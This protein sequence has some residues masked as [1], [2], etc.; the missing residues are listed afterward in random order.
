MIQIKDILR[1]I[2]SRASFRFAE[3]WDNSG[4]QVG[5]PDFAVSKVMIALDPATG[6]LREAHELGCQC[7]VTHHPLLLQAVKSIWTDRWPGSVIALAL[8]SGIGI[9]AAHTNLDAARE[10]TNAQLG[11][12]LGLEDCVPLEADADLFADE[13]YLGM[14]IVG[15]LPR[16][17]TLEKLAHELRGML[18]CPAVRVTGEPH[19]KISRVA[20]CTGSGGS[21][22]GKVLAFRADVFLTGDMKYHDARLAEESGLAVI[23]I[24]H[25]ASEKLVL[26]PLGEYLGARAESEGEKLEI[27]ISGT[28]KDP[29]RIPS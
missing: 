20:L 6:V 19:R 3:P 1:W 12:L 26:K 14:G 28:E 18:Q 25:F 23:D 2:D 22:I 16:E 8:T 7:V 11:A 5:N 24:G 4:L 27:I 17:T 10:G 29:F 9:I 15:M 13:K 21:L